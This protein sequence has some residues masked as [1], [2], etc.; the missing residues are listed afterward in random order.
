[1]SPCDSTGLLRG[2]ARW[3][4]LR[5][6]VAAGAVSAVFYML[7]PAVAGLD[8]GLLAPK[9]TYR[10]MWLNVLG[11]H[12]RLPIETPKPLHVLLAGVLG[13][14][15]GFYVVTCLMVGVC[16]AAAIRLGRAIT[17]SSSPGL[18]AVVAA[19]ALR[20]GFTSSVLSGG[21][22]PFHVAFVLLCLGALADGR[23]GFAA[24]MMFLACLVRPETWLLAPVPLLAAFVARRRFS[25]LLLL[26]FAAPFVWAACD[27]AMT[28]DWCYSMHVTSYYRVASG[29]S[30]AAAGDFW[31]SV[32]FEMADVAGGFPLVAG[33]VGLDVWVWR[34]GRSRTTSGRMRGVEATKTAG[35]GVKESRIPGL[36]D[37]RGRRAGY[38]VGVVLI[39]L[40]LPLFGSWLVSLSGRVLQMGRFQYPSVV[41]LGLLA[42]SA[43]FLLLGD[44]APHWLAPALSAAI[45][46]SACA[47]KEVAGSIRRARVME[48]R[49]VAYDPVADTVKHL[50]ET[51]DAQI[52][53]VSARR[54]DYFAFLLGDTGSWKLLSVRELSSAARALPVGVE[55]GVLVYY[56]RDEIDE[57]SADSVLRWVTRVWP[58]GVVVDTVVRFSAGRGGVWSIRS[59]Q[60]S[61]EVESGVEPGTV[62]NVGAR[63]GGTRTKTSD[64]ESEYSRRQPEASP[65]RTASGLPRSRMNVD[66][67]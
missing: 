19:L 28:G 21:V 66:M 55:S 50:V 14:G 31:N 29:I 41:M 32:L 24:F 39:F 59:R 23:P 58:A 63:T 6:D 18:F 43:P 48:T 60:R 15:L 26:P 4:G 57:P 64:S 35:E 22:E 44:R 10:L 17:G 61:S 8:Y 62:P 46:L 3:L 27:R 65:R 47:P 51:G 56:D 2:T 5:S 36:K 67:S 11:A 42:A 54:L 53:I 13:S 52:V 49:A 7:L 9:G 38:F 40:V 20:G 16:F 12:Y 30:A 33:V 45:V 34:W 37:S 25:P 1:M